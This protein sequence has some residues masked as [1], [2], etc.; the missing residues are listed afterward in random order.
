MYEY[1]AKI[2][3]VVDGDTVD[4]EVDLGFHVVITMKFRLAGINAPE[5]KTAEGKKAKSA[6]ISVIEGKTVKIL[7]IKDKQE[8]YGRYLAIILENDKNNVNNWLVEQG[9]ATPYMV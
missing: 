2:I 7:T 3:R 8:K 4:A 1:K 9:L 5:M 6:L